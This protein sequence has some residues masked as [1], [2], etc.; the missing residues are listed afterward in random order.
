MFVKISL[1]TSALLFCSVSLS[2][3]TEYLPLKQKP[4]LELDVDTLLL[5]AES[6]VTTRPIAIKQIKSAYSKVCTD[7]EY[8]VCNRIKPYLKSSNLQIKQAEITVQTSDRERSTLAN[9]RGINYNSD[10]ITR[11]SVGGTFND[12]LAY[13]VGM[14]SSDDVIQLEDSYLS[15]GTQ[16]GQLDIGNKP[17]WFSP[18]AN[19]SMLI[20]THAPTITSLSWKG[21]TATSWL[22]F[23]YELFI[24][25]LSESNNIYFQQQLTTGKPLITGMHFEF[26]PWTGF[27]L[28]VNRI[29]Q[30]G[31]SRAGFD[32][33][34]LIKAFIDPSG[35]DNTSS[36]LSVDEQ[37]GNQAASIVS[38]ID[39]AGER[40]FSLY[41]EYAGEDTSRGSNFRLGNSALS[42]G[43]FIPMLTENIAL[44]FEW[45]D[46]QNAWYAHHVYQDG[47]SN[48][49]NLLGHWAAEYRYR[50]FN[51]QGDAVGAQ[52]WMLKLNW[53]ANLGNYYV[54]E[55][56]STENQSYSNYD[57]SK[58]Y[59]AKLDW[60]R[61]LGD[62]QIK[63]SFELGRDSFT[64]AFYR[65]SLGFNW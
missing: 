41:F 54:L 38:K 15:I 40:P 8:P 11:F 5:L 53:Q 12:Y 2:Q 42:A 47:I 13:S 31:G 61:S 33:K 39:F 64:Q 6:A 30:S 43:L 19:S 17:H 63:S 28:A 59:S 21:I 60:H 56:N 18:F 48:E 27:S 58:A 10:L 16:W 55:L 45:S 44:T 23:N 32:F 46:W 26:S 34:E 4:Q 49:G 36:E 35:A 3:V 51:A 65:F 24:G 29:M 20:S 14:Q 7:I 9:Q 57:Y 22:D 37:F 52:H 25:E 50:D 62:H 1:I